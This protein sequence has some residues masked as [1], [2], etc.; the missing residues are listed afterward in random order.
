MAGVQH[1]GRGVGAPALPA[2]LVE[3][4]AVTDANAEAFTRLT[5]A[6]PVLVG[7]RPA[8]EVVPG[9]TPQ[10][11]LTSGA[12]LPWEAYTGGQRRAIL[13]A[14]VYEGLAGDLDEADAAIR[15]GRIRLGA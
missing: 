13:H 1:R 10:T 8:G 5:T 6:D 2:P 14:A 15:A 3:G 7:V 12:P 11:I 9:M 4:A